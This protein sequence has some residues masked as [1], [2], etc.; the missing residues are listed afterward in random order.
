M[1]I[2]PTIQTRQAIKKSTPTTRPE[3]ELLLCCARTRIDPIIEKRIKELLQQQIDWND[4]IEISIHHG[5]IQLLY[6]NLSQICP[7]AIPKAILAELQ[8]QFFVNGS[9]SLALTSELNRILT[10]FEEHEILAIPYKGPILAASVYGN[11]AL[12]QFGDL[13]IF[14]QKQDVLKA[15]QVLI[16]ANYQPIEQLSPSQEEK[17]LESHYNYKFKQNH[18]CVQLLE[19]HWAIGMKSPRFGSGM[20]PVNVEIDSFWERLE[21]AVLANKTVLHFPPEDLLLILCL[22]GAKDK[23]RSLKWLCDVSELINTY[24]KMDWQWAIEKANSLDMEWQLCLGLCLIQELLGTELPVEIQTHRWQSE[25][26]IQWLAAQI[27]QKLK[28]N[29]ENY[30]EEFER[31]LFR[32]S[33]KGWKAIGYV[34]LW[35]IHLRTKRVR[36]K[37]R[38]GF[39]LLW[40]GITPSKKDRDF[41]PLPKFLFFLYYLIRPI[42]LGRKYRLGLFKRFLPFS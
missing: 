4:L 6:W 23:W 40:F 10:L 12:R 22:H 13:D 14:V 37:V 7:E 25:R 11:L 5:V 1:I 31:F 8:E 38:K 17:L 27:C 16:D 42:R 3:I 28:G 18:G 26:A 32:F 19:L 34:F 39:N 20:T 33:S 15:K 41:L 29:T 36:K 35:H 24:P 30:S 9:V 21:S 2:I